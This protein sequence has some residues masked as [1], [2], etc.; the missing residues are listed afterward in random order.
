MGASCGGG[1]F[2][3]LPDHCVTAAAAHGL[4]ED[5]NVKRLQTRTRHVQSILFNINDMSDQHC[6][7]EFRFT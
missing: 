6:I 3:D 1:D 5:E 2:L 4:K 7:K